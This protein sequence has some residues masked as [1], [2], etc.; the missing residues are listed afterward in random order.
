[1]M[2]SSVV[3]DSN[4]KKHVVRTIHLNLKFLKN[5]MQLHQISYSLMHIRNADKINNKFLDLLMKVITR[6]QNE[7]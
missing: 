7:N 5:E 3:N 6:Y 2:R 4:I 1:M